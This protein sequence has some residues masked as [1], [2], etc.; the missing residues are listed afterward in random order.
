MSQRIDPLIVIGVVLAVVDDATQV[1]VVER[2][3][4]EG[5]LLWQFP[6]G[7]VEGG[8]TEA[9]AVEREI[10]EETGVLGRAVER[11]GERIHPTT[12]RR[13]AYWRVEY[14]GGSPVLGDLGDLQSVSWVP[15]E[16]VADLFGTEIFPAVADL[17]EKWRPQ[18]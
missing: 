6:G 13:I 5:K 7:G 1:L 10:S 17:L 3:Y 12:G 8:E 16:R 18:G 14:V 11:L 9:A 4:G 15:V 2:R